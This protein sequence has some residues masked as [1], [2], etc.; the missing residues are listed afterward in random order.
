MTIA[1]YGK[2]FSEKITEPGVVEVTREMTHTIGGEPGLSIEY[3]F[4]GL[5]R[6]GLAHFVIHSD[7]LYRF[8]Y[9]DSLECYVM[10]KPPH[11]LLDV[12]SRLVNSFHFTPG[13]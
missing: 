9:T 13:P 1:D 10:G 7:T 2:A 6:L 8:E 5:N 11:Y 4:G 12:Y 3:R